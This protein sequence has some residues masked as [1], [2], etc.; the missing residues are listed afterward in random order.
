M[1]TNSLFPDDASEALREPAL[2]ASPGRSLA[3]VIRGDEAR[4]LFPDEPAPSSSI[5]ATIRGD[6]EDGSPAWRLRPAVSH[7]RKGNPDQ[8]AR[9]LQMQVKTGLP[10]ELIE[11]NLDEV[12]RKAA[13]H[14]FD[15][16]TFRRTSPM[17]AAWLTENPQHPALVRDDVER[18]SYIER[19]FRYTGQ[20][21]ERGKLTTELAGIGE[22]AFMGRATHEQRRRQADI[23]ATL[24]DEID[25]GITGFVEQIPGAVANQL[26]IFGQS[27]FGKVKGAAIGGITG[28]ALGPV[29][30]RGLGTVAGGQ[31]AAL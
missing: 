15:A 20:Q 6:R 22:S 28:A 16:E 13:E 9:V 1:A 17:L 3:S 30:S 7:G 8:A 14:D 4:S 24:A 12:E 29:V 23:D 11:R 26:P 31:A 5:A 21:F 18:L 27:I 10:V 2:E 25:Y 19:Q